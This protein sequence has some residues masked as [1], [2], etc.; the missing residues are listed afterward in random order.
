MTTIAYREGVLAADSQVN[1]GGGRCGSV[2]KAWKTD[3]GSLWAFSGRA[4]LQEGCQ[5]WSLGQRQGDPPQIEDSTLVCI[6][7]DG[8]VREWC[9]KGWLQSQAEFFAWGSGGEYAMGAMAMG[10]SAE[11][12]VVAAIRFDTSSGGDLTVLSLDPLPEQPR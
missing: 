2:V 12:A 10:A 11:Q 5:K 8:R 3:D 7:P 9:G 1:C 6:T 4:S